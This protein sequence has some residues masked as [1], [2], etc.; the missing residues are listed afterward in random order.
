MKYICSIN[1]LQTISGHWHFFKI[2]NVL[3][4][5]NSG[6]YI[7]VSF[8]EDIHNHIVNENWPIFKYT[9]QWFIN[10]Y[11][12]LMLT[13]PDLKATLQI[14]LKNSQFNSLWLNTNINERNFHKKVPHLSPK[15]RSKLTSNCPSDSAPPSSNFL[16]NQIKLMDSLNVES[17]I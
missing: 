10:S 6:I 8:I 9:K 11:Y 14:A 15:F 1:S 17:K 13:L 12:Y 7:H 2:L 4:I 5:F 16:R 3:Q